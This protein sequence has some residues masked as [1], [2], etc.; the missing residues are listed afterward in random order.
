MASVRF[1]FVFGET[2]RQ[3]D[4]VEDF[5]DFFSPLRPNFYR[6]WP[7]RDIVSAKKLSTENDRDQKTDIERPVSRAIE[8][9]KGRN[10][11]YIYDF[12]LRGSTSFESD[13]DV[14]EKIVI[15]NIGPNFADDFGI[16]ITVQIIILD[17]EVD[18]ER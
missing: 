6:S 11:T 8:N 16:P 13:V 12:S 7:V 17:L 3:V 4:L 14:S 2:F 9:V 5:L 18:P 15:E 1:G 10:G